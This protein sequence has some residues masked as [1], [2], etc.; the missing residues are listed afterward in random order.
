MRAWLELQSR[1]GRF[2]SSPRIFGPAHSTPT[3]ARSFA[4]SF[5][6]RLKA[7]CKTTEGPIDAYT[8][9]K[10]DALEANRN[11]FYDAC[12]FQL[13]SIYLYLSSHPQWFAIKSFRSK[14]D[15]FWGNFFL[16]NFYWSFLKCKSGNVTKNWA[17]YFLFHRLLTS[18]R[19]D[20][21]KRMT[22][23]G[24]VAGKKMSMKTENI[25]SRL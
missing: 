1:V 22:R 24:F 18:C 9:A 16:L 3:C 2:A 10:W 17:I 7:S 19:N 21:W 14:N 13:V 4:R 15:T 12:L 20:S 11:L 5:V 25:S 6:C 23:M 8:N